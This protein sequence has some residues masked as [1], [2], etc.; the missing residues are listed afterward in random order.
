MAFWKG[1]LQIS[2]A[3]MTRTTFPT[4]IP[5]CRLCARWRDRSPAVGLSRAVEDA[6]RPADSH[7]PLLVRVDGRIRRHD[8]ARGYW[9]GGTI[10]G[11]LYAK[12]WHCVL[13]KPR[14]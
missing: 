6:L 1:I 8:A 5:V 11:I 4:P 12:R 10:S 3:W 7:S 14:V 9:P 13:H 2:A